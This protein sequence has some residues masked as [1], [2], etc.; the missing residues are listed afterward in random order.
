MRPSVLDRAPADHDAPDPREASSSAGRK[1]RGARAVV[2]GGTAVLVAG[3]LVPP[4]AQH[5]VRS[6]VD[7]VPVPFETETVDRSTPALL[8]AMADI[9]EYHAA[10]GDF[11]IVVDV[12]RDTRWVPSFVSGERTEFLAGGSV[13]AMVDFS[14]I[15]PGSVDVD[16]E[17][18]EVEI[19]LPAPELAEPVIDTEVS[20]VLDRDR[21]MVQRM[22]ELLDDDGSDDSAVY[23]LAEAKLAAAAAESD[24]EGRAEA[25]T[26]RM[27]T[28]LATSLGFETV[29]VVF[30]EQPGV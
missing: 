6:L 13:D 19:R 20:R 29:T 8:T 30:E 1:V 24:L 27:L 15:G 22:G 16:A 9:G 3:L 23:Q 10:T 12:E 14:G 7:S 11:Q 18:T 5:A 4:L 28:G 25:S 17:R 21:G 2:L 26:R